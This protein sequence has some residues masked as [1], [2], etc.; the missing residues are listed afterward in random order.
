MYFNKNTNHVILRTANVAHWLLKTILM[1]TIVY[2]EGTYVTWKGQVR[3][4]RF[5][6]QLN[7]V[8]IKN[9]ENDFKIVFT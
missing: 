7:I 5:V 6:D 4:A 1:V 9:N 8:N 2:F 3:F